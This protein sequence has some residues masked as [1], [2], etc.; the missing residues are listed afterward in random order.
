MYKFRYI[1]MHFDNR[2]GGGNTVDYIL[3]FKDTL[4][5]V[6]VLCVTSLNNKYQIY[7]RNIVKLLRRS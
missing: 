2:G 7:L 4:S 6:F 5:V 1:F 3:L